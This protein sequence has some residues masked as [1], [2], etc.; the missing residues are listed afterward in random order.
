MLAKRLKKILSVIIS[1]TQSAFIPRRLIIDNIMVAREA[2]CSM[3]SRQRGNNGSMTIKLNMS[4]A[5]DMIECRFLEEMMK[6]MCLCDKW[7]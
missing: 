7:A 3:K 5:Y 2:L 6:K 4:K 1:P